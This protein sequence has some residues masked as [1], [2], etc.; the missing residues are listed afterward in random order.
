MNNNIKIPEPEVSTA[1]GFI[2]I[3][4]KRIYTD[5]N[6]NP[7]CDQPLTE[8]ECKTFLKLNEII[9]SGYILTDE[10]ISLMTSGFI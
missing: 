1:N 2:W 6:G 5:N 10:A 9:K 7:V 4:K 3:N 8:I